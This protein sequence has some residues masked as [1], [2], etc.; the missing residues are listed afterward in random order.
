MAIA[1]SFTKQSLVWKQGM[2]NWAEAG[3]IDELNTVFAAVP[4]A[5]PKL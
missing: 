3:T 4:P 5:P 1:G 2:T